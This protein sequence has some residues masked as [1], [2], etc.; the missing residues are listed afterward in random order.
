VHGPGAGYVAGRYYEG[1]AAS[2]ATFQPANGTMRAGFVIYVRRSQAFDRIAC[3]IT[4]AGSAGALVRLGLYRWT[5]NGEPGVLLVDAGTVSAE[6]AGVTEATISQTL[7]PGIYVPTLVTQGAPAT[8][9][10]YRSILGHN[11]TMGH[12]SGD[13]G[14]ANNTFQATGTTGALP[15]PFATSPVGLGGGIPRLMLR[16]A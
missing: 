12:A 10:I 13:F 1:G 7:A 15:S 14:A 16:A 3:Q 6:G 9:P 2:V 11:G 5:V 8:L 4:T